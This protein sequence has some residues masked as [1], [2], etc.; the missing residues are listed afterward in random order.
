M[1]YPEEKANLGRFDCVL[2]AAAKHRVNVLHDLDPAIRIPWVEVTR[3]EQTV[4]IDTDG[5][6]HWAMQMNGQMQKCSWDAI[7]RLISEAGVVCTI[8]F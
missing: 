7:E 1:L 8:G 2:E 3:G 6:G 4:T 5:N